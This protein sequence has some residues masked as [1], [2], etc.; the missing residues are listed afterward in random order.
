MKWK[1]ENNNKEGVL[2]RRTG[3]WGENITHFL[4]HPWKPLLLCF[5]L[6]HPQQGIR[7][8]PAMILPLLLTFQPNELRAEKAKREIYMVLK[9]LVTH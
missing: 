8:L 9:N 5:L 4:G 6:P 2:G 7:V 3:G 1:A